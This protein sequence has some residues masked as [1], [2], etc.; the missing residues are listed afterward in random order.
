MSA[1]PQDSDAATSAFL[2]AYGD[3]AIAVESGAGLPEVARAANRALGASV[4]VLDTS[5]RV[6]AVACASPDDERAVLGVASGTQVLD[7]KLADN[8]VGRLLYRPREA[9]PPPALVRMVGTL[10]ANEVWRAAGPARAS[11]AAIGS[12]LSDLLERRVTDRDNI[13]A[14]GH[15]LG[16]DLS[17]GASVIVVRTHPQ[18]PEEGDWR[19]RV[20]GIVERAAR[21]GAPG[22]ALAANVERA[23][24]DADEAALHRDGEFV[25]LVA[26]AEPGLVHKTAELLLRE[27]EIN[28]SSYE[29]AVGHSRPAADAADAHRAGAEAL[30][31]ANVAEAQ[32]RRLLAFED[33]GA[34]R[35]LLPALSE[36]PAELRR[37]HEETIAPL[38]AYDAQYDTE[39]VRTLESFLDADGNVAKT[40]QKLYTHRHTIRYRLERVRELCGLDVSSTEGRERLGLGLKATR[41]LGIAA[42]DRPIDEP[43]TEAGLVP[44]GADTLRDR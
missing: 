8:D 9:A 3:V 19:A 1:V 39:L 6:L 4:A 29:L 20:L 35:L 27:L 10:I 15:E 43:G 28:L 33:T 26:G 34:Y 22:A 16:V 5:S 18:T 37:F 14:R 2:D 21:A 23:S 7:L 44:P 36:D 12:F 25:V 30:L 42:V 31:A 13:L 17:T 38:L 40:A 41:V 24:R 32:G 11:E